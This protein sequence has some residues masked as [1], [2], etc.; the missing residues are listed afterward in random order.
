MLSKLTVKNVALIENAEI[1][2]SEGL[3]VLSGETG[4]GKSVILDALNFVLG[5]KADRTMIR[6]GAEECF[7][8][9]EFL[10]NENAEAVRVLREMDID[11][12]G[13][14]VISRRFF[15]SGKN[16]VKINGSAVT[17][18]M[19]RSVTS[20]L[21]DVHG[22]SEHFFLL[23]EAN[24][25]KTLD[26]ICGEAVAEK[27]RELKNVLLEFREKKHAAATLGGNAEERERRLE[28]LRYAVDEIKAADW[29][30]GEEEELLQ[31]RNKINNLEKIL[32]SV[33]EA[34][35]FLSA[36]GGACDALR[37]ARRAINAVSA[38]DGA[39]ERISERLECAADEADDIAATLSDLADELYFDENEANY[40]E[41]RLDEL[42][43][44]KRK[45]GVKEQAELAAILC[46]KVKEFN[47]LSDG[48]AQAEKLQRQIE[49]ITGRIYRLCVELTSLRKSGAQKFCAR[50]CEELKTLNIPSAAFSVQ[51]KEYTPGDAAQAGENGLDDI[52]FMFSANAGEPQKP[53]SKIIS[54][55]E[56]SRFMLAIKTQLSAEN[57]IST[58]VFDEIDAG[59]SGKTAKAV[60]EKFAKIAKNT[61]IIAVS[62]LAQIACMSDREFLIEKREEGGKT[63]TLIRLLSQ[64][65]QKE[66]IVRLLGGEKDERAAYLHAEEL[67]KKAREFKNTL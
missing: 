8:K 38:L 36:D 15:Q 65:E 14:I 33:K 2:F 22:Q 21:V 53:L 49:E 10:L 23:S 12:E 1:E 42:R 57:G 25:L 29:K 31:K 4:A 48:A 46:E 7:V 41:N 67:I 51:F 5:A 40:V 50:V 34:A 43:A 45:Y 32:G 17:A 3:N 63:H 18:T 19:L 30:E 28:V 37:Q 47:L 59:I 62:H 54:G 44:L 60:G 13:E 11:S 26:G 16:A 52:S 20:K 27:K 66:E 39:Y 56:M 35:E 55:G 6:Y 24:Q 58:Y 64:A 61:Q 9:A